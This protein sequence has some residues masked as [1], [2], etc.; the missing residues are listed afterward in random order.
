[1]LKWKIKIL[2]GRSDCFARCLLIFLSFVDA[3]ELAQDFD[4]MGGDSMMSD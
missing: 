4:D 3:H 2:F 1:M